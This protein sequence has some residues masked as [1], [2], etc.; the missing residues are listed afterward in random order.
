MAN[1]WREW[2]DL[3]EGMG[4]APIVVKKRPHYRVRLTDPADPARSTVITIPSSA[5]D[6]RARLNMVAGVRRWL[7]G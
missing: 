3:L 5:S 2:L 7:R 4:V 1:T 6:R